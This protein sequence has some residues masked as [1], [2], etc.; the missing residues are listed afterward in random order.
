MQ[1]K[2]SSF[3][4]SYETAFLAALFLVSAV[5]IYRWF[6]VPHQNYLAA[7]QKYESAINTLDKKRKTISNDLKADR[8]R[9]KELHEKL[10][11]LEGKIFDQLGERE[12]FGSIENFC[13]EAGCKMLL[14]T[15]SQSSASGSK[16]LRDIQKND[17]VN[18]SAA[19]LVVEGRYGNIII[20]MNKLQ[21]GQKLVRINPLS[22]NSDNKNPGFLKCDMTVTIYVTSEEKDFRNVLYK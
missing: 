17:S 13:R 10:D 19:H 15:F 16:S 22:I 18:P 4:G 11:N 9:Y 12:F 3:F 8:I 2:V 21:D 14:L 7:A 1:K 5:A 6:I 20:L